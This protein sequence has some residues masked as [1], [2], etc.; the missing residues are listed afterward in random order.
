MISDLHQIRNVA[1]AIQKLRV[2]RGP[3]QVRCEV[4][5]KRPRQALAKKPHPA[6]KP[7]QLI[8]PIR[9]CTLHN[10]TTT[11]LSALVAHHT[12]SF[13]NGAKWSQPCSMKEGACHFRPL[14]PPFLVKPTLFTNHQHHQYEHAE[15][16]EEYLCLHCVTTEMKKNTTISQHASSTEAT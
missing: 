9:N 11:S 5:A 13:H 7:P 6:E 3:L 16:S 12:Q 15:T 14:L 2:T 8:A 1:A 10:E 4:I